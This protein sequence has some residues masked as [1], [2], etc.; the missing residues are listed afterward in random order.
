MKR[1]T[2]T[3]ILIFI[4]LFCLIYLIFTNETLVFEAFEVQANTTDVFTEEVKETLTYSNLI[5]VRKGTC[6]LTLM[7]WLNVTLYF[8]LIPFIIAWIFAFRIN[9]KALRKKQATNNQDAANRN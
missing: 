7:G 6:A 3:G 5:C 8:I 1:G 2:I 4:I 9:R